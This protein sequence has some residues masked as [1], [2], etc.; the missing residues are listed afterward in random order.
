MLYKEKNNKGIF[1]NKL[2]N[3]FKEIRA[4]QFEDRVQTNRLLS[5]L[6]RG[7]LLPD[8][9]ESWLD[10]FKAD[11]STLAIDVL[12]KLSQIE[13]YNTDHTVMLD[14]ADA[15]F[16]HDSLNEEALSIKCSVLYIS[17]KKGIAIDV[18]NNFCKEYLQL[19]GESYQPALT[20]II[21]SK[22]KT[23]GD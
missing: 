6:L 8:I 14:I 11:F 17:G 1:K 23:I 13:A 18:F 12:L 20:D 4:N 19:L 21:I 3:L 9:E 2:I 5:L 16:K 10:D 22:K 15:I 7:V